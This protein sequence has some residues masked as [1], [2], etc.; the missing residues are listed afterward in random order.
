MSGDLTTVPTVKQWLGITGLAIADITRANPAAVTLAGV[1]Q[2]PLLNGVAYTIEGVY[3]LTSVP[4]GDYV[5]AVTGPK[6][7]TIA[8]DTSG[9]TDAYAGGGI[10]GVTDALIQ[11]LISA[12]ST[13]IQRYCTAIIAETAYQEVRNGLGGARMMTKQ[14]PIISVASVYVNGISIP[15]R[16]PLGPGSTTQPGGFVNDD[17]SVMLSGYDFCRGAQNVTLNYT[18]GFDPTPPDIEQACI[19]IVGDW[20]KRRDRIGKLSEGIE[21]QTISFTNA[22]IPP[23]TLAVLNTYNTKYP[24]Y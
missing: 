24:V 11:R 16:G 2:T 17:R 19:D 8:V 10:V 13:F 15:A 9:D 22:Q 4:N 14:S 3:G 23:A 1:P 12:A 18:A 7:F 20:F 5:I 21:G 6:T